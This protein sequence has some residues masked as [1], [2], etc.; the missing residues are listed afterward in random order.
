MSASRSIHPSR[1][2]F[3]ELQIPVFVRVCVVSRYVEG[4]DA[5]MGDPLGVDRPCRS[6]EAFVERLLDAGAII[7]GKT[8]LP[9]RG[10]S[11]VK[12]EKSGRCPSALWLAWQRL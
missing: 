3:R 4:L 11:A 6:N 12:G 7:F 9:A 1:C 2:P 8:N 5:T 10:R